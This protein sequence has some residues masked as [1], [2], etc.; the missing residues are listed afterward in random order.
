MGKAATAWMLRTAGIAAIALACAQPAQA[1]PAHTRDLQECAT[2]TQSLADQRIA[3]CTKLLQSG[4]LKGKPLGV[5]YGLRGLAYLDRG[6]VPHAIGDLNN[7]IQLAPDFAPAYQNRGNAWYARGNFGQALADYDATIK[8]DPES[9]SPY[10]NRATVRRDLGY[11]EGALEDYGRAI[12]LGSDRAGAYRGRGELYLRAG[13]KAKALADFDRALKLDPDAPTFMLRAQAREASNDLNGALADYQEASHRDAKSVAA[14]TAIAG[15]WKKRG[16]LDKAIITYDRAIGLEQNRPSTYK[17]RAEAYAARGE[18]KKAMDDISRALKFS[19][20]A[21]LLKTRG[22]LR[23]DDG[24]LAG[25][26][27]DAD[28]ILKINAQNA[29]AFAL[30]GAAFARKKDYARA[31]PDLDRAI[32]GDD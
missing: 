24:D 9:A 1:A 7:A 6:D 10:I 25:A 18:R 22:A 13:D 28:A 19:W 2:Q 20:N 27:H 21:D 15:I 30:R 32:D 4:R 8:L 23:L 29:D 17:L 11:T 12:S 3:A 16:N 5:T 26:A 14:L 31:L